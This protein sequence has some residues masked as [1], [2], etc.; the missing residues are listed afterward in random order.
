MT[1][2][3]RTLRTQN[4]A[5]GDV[6]AKVFTR[7]DTSTAYLWAMNPW[8]TPFTLTVPEGKSVQFYAAPQGERVDLPPG[9]HRLT[10]PQEKWGRV[11]GLTRDELAA[12]LTP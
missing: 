3:A 7:N 2:P 4:V 10:L 8:A 11:V 5:A 12:A 6:R 1:T 9:T